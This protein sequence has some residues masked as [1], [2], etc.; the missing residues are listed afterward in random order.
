VDIHF[1]SDLH[2]CAER[3]ALTAVFE[4]YLAG[5]ARTASALTSWAISSNTGPAMT[6][7][8]IRSTRGS[9]DNSHLADAGCR[10]FFMPGNRDFLLG[11]DFARRAKLEILPEPA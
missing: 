11:A 2:L 4:R 6:T 7:S 5:P 9:P 3:P 1:I 10:V 8:T